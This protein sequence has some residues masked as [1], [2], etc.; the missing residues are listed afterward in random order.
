MAVSPCRVGAQ[1]KRGCCQPL[2]E[3]FCIEVSRLL[4][5]RELE[6]LASAGLTGLLTLFHAG[7]TCE[8]AFRFEW[9]AK[10]FVHFKKG[11]A[12]RKAHGA[13]LA[14]DSATGGFYQEIVGMN[15]V[16]DLQRTEDL[17]LKR[18]ADKIF[19]EVATVDFDRACSG[20]HADGCN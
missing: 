6:A 8:E 3:E 4:A 7:I 5:F 13:G 20:L 18:D 17:V 19:S 1:K 10:L 16:S 15:P 12:D 9:Y 2:D 11:T 14:I